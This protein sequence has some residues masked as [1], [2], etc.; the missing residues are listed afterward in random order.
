MPPSPAGLGIALVVR[1]SNYVAMFPGA[2]L[3]EGLR[4]KRP[5]PAEKTVVPVA[6]GLIAGDNPLDIVSALLIAGSVIAA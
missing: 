4:R 2:A 1:G 5:A 3:A 6:S